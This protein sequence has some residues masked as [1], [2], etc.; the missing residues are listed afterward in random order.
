MHLHP[1]PILDDQ[2][3][4]GPYVHVKFSVIE[5][6]FSVNFHLFSKLFFILN[7]QNQLKCKILGIRGKSQKKRAT[8]FMDSSKVRWVF[9]CVAIL[10]ILKNNNICKQTKFENAR[11]K[12]LAVNSRMGSKLLLRIIWFFARLLTASL[13]S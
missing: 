13:R 6:I 12:M 5:I 4:F 7:T 9:N 3:W 1:K 8:S 10:Q 11:T 2:I